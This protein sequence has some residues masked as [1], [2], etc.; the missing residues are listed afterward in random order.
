MK[1]PRLT[2]KMVSLSVAGSLSL[3]LLSAANGAAA[4][5]QEPVS[6]TDIK[7]H[8]AEKDIAQWIADGWITGYG[9]GSFQ[10]NKAV[11]RAEFIAL[12]NRAFGYA[13]AGSSAFKDLPSSAWSYLDIQKAV[14]AGYITGFA[15]G[16]VHP[17]A[18]IT[19][20]E[21]AV[22]VERLLGLKP[23]EQDAGSFRDAASIPSWSK[24]AI[25]AAM[26]NGIMGGY[27]DKTFRPANDATR[28]E[29]VVILSHALQ[30][31][32]APATFAEAGVYGPETGV[33]TISGDVV[34]SAPG[35]TL[36]NTV[37][38][39]NLTFAAGVGE[40]DA[41]LDHVT[42]K[43]TTLVQGGGANS[44]HF[45]DSVLLTIV[46][47]KSAG[48]VR[49]VAE[50]S[51]TVASVVMQ[52]GATLEESELTGEGFTDVQLSALLPKGA[53][54]TLIGS[55][56][57]V[58]VSSV[59][60]QIAIP[61]GS[62]QQITVGENAEGNGFD[63][64]ASA[65]AVN[66][67]LYAAAQFVGGGTIE[68]VQTM[69]Q[70]A[71]DASTFQTKPWRM[72]DGSGSAHQTPPPSS[73]LTQQQ[74]DQQAADRVSALIAALPAEADLTLAANEAGVGAANDAFAA[75]NTARQ[76][77]VSTENQAKLTGAV[78][79]IAELKADKAAADAVVAL[80]AAL[81]AADILAL[82]DESAVTAA[83][84]AFAAL[85]AVR[86]ALVPVET[87]SKLAGA[88]ARIAE[89]K[90]DK[91][92]A[93]AVA[94]LIAALPATGGLKLADEAA[95]K[96]ADDAFAALTAGQQALVTEENRA[97]L[98]GS[99]ARIAELK[100]DKAAA[101][102]VSARIAELPATA[103]LTLAD[104]DGVG[105]ASDAFAALSAAR[106]A[107]VA[108]AD[109]DKLADAVDR[110]AELIA[111]QAA[112][113]AVTA[114]IAALPAIASL[115]LGDEAG[116]AAA[117]DAYA[118]LT[119]VQQAL[120]SPA[121]VT[122]LADAVA[123]IGVLKADK[124]AADAVIALI[125]ALPPTGSLALADETAVNGANGAFAALTGDQQT[126][127][128]A[129][130]QTALADAV[131]QIAKLQAD[132]A[133]ADA[134]I[135][136]IAALPAAADLALGDEADVT[137]ANDAF[138]ALTGDQQALVASAD[139]TKLA[140]AV[141]QIAK[142]KADRAAADAVIAQIGAL[143]AVADLALG[144]EADVTAANDAYAALTSDQQALVSPA[145]QT[146]LADAV[147]QI[148]KL[149]ADRAAA[150][151]V[152][153]QIGALPAVADLALGDEADVAAANDAFSALTGDQQALVPPA[154]QT[155]LAEAVAQIAK[156][157]AD[158]AAADAVIAQIA[159]LP[160]VAD[161]ALGDEADVAA[162]NDAFSALTGDQQALVPPAN[163]TK[164][165]DAVAQIAKLKADQAAADAVIA[166]IGALPEAADLALGDEADVTAAN[167]AF[168]ALT[169]DQQALVPPANQTKLADAVAQIAKLKAD[170]AA[171]DAVIA[172]IAALPAVA[173]LALVNEAAVGAANDAYAALT[174]DQQALVPPADHT[175]L[176][177][178]VARIGVLKA[179]RAAA[180]AV[181][182]LIE[183]LPPTGSLTL[184]SET[185]V[186]GANQAFTA[187]TGDQQTL[188]SAAN[189]TKLADAVARIGVL[190]ADR[191]AADAVIALIGALPP[192]GSLTLANE[193]AVNGAN[194]AFTAL[195]GDQ[196]ALVSSNDKNALTA[197]V[198]RIADMKADKA[199]ADLVTAQIA[200]LPAAASL[201]LANEAAV[202][203]AHTAFEN[204]TP[205]QQTYIAA[206]DLSALNAAVVKISDL[207]A[208]RAAADAVI[209]QIAALPAAGSLTLADE[210]A[211]TAARAA[212][213]G[214]TAAR[215]AL[216]TNLNVLVQAETKIDQLN[217][218]YLTSLPLTSL[219]F[220]T[221]A[222][223]QAMGVSSAVPGSTDFANNTIDFT[224]EF[225]YANVPRTVH[226]LL[227]WNIDPNGFTPGQIVG[228][229]VD[230]DIQQFCL[231]NH[232]DLMQR[233][234]EAYG[235]GN[236]FTI[237][238]AMP[239]AQGS[240]KIGGRDA[241]RFFG[242][243]TIFAGTDTNTS[244]N[245]AFTVGDG[246]RTASIALTG[247]YA[248]MD[249]FV[250]AINSKLRSAN[251]SAVAAKVDDTHFTI[252]PSVTGGSIT[253]GGADKDQFFSVLQLN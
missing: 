8:W 93:D 144:D 251:V 128:S 159:A 242:A 146:K 71:R 217:H 104:A 232:I 19:R 56:D 15:D 192:T 235:E 193:A 181:I 28:A 225:T 203:A 241:S 46:V 48:T 90:A 20:Q 57:D 188:V 145:D 182:A 187:L 105:A 4:E 10:P 139:Q 137:A 111:D 52:T 147:A 65:R 134:V 207:K 80:A 178:A 223:T 43:G 74:I 62:V 64:G 150:D 101:D 180:D 185:A 236:T 252:A 208:D 99:A 215:Q 172:Q 94:A 148:A 166:Q 234:I 22:I 84:D 69:N 96:A 49:I 97:K 174:S 45:E 244:K 198:A 102:A 47:D 119:G 218:P 161:L 247:T 173:D 143:P 9:D 40:G 2:K 149:Q 210:A 78:A 77:L 135:A 35:V 16:T 133:A 51:T 253:I 5:A 151:A 154:N 37:I 131:A 231:D 79:R 32:A 162:A 114:R 83:N 205:A 125:E 118:A 165:A 169:G 70:A 206:N 110:I 21:I 61:S 68:S 179:D 191:A 91:A 156:L 92:A 89:L 132:R 237:R 50:G 38:E 58:N 160:A 170:R 184:A 53:L 25:G 158:R 75:L 204:L 30:A 196:Q 33:Q 13:A 152:I 14:Q 36:R 224:I 127:V 212:Y 26:A 238:G 240:F 175:K 153:A 59:K 199:A 100:A 183:A 107:L 228:G 246:T 155:T 142:L 222:A 176:A 200:A 157:Q 98:T 109:Q 140:D 219:D 63:V 129:A 124:A 95:L 138:A 72:Q 226:V 82:A 67:V 29:A 7:G 230:S 27:E 116:V 108:P 76:A 245:R 73:G 195:T 190:K 103:S 211:V 117:N 216:V 248:T 227:N 177:D 66:L 250:S 141:A 120:V 88:A 167:D 213:D 1:L 34:I 249:S 6:A 197:A 31:K 126:L 44:L 12:V 54:I 239:G 243:Q 85:T 171:A 41:I 221:I 81:P 55:F 86:Q 130:N 24:G 115:A 201:T 123:R 112:A 113:D 163:Q 39:G 23:S 209:A 189:Q 60:V 194:Q 168:S 122:K 202:N 186:N 87:Q 42:V 18:P 214:L 164:L 229:V 11:T 233:P 121:D 3:S 106:K 220:A 136:Q 17:N